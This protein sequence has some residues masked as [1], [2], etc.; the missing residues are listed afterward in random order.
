MGHICGK[1]A[2]CSIL[3]IEDQQ[4]ILDKALYF[5]PTTLNPVHVAAYF[6]IELSQD[7]LLSGIGGYLTLAF[8]LNRLLA[9]V[10]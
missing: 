2:R 4:I 8:G 6:N 5:N 7:S 9:P 3:K 10:R 1:G